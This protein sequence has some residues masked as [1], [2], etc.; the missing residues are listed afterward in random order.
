MMSN[1]WLQRLSTFTSNKNV[2]LVYNP[3]SLSGREQSNNG[4]L[5][6]LFL[7]RLGK[8]KGVYDLLE[9]VNQN[10]EYFQSK[11]ARFILAGDGEVE[12][13]RQFVA[14]HELTDLVEVPGWIL[15]EQKEKYLKTS[16]ILILPSYNEQ[17]P[18]SILEGMGYGYPI[19]ATN[20]ASIPEMVKHGENGYLFEPGDI[21]AMTLFIQ[22][23][24]EDVSLR[25][26]M[27]R[28]SQELVK[29]KFESTKIV[30]Q[31]VSIYENL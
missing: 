1:L 27:G 22:N 5:N 9:C 17:M 31:L 29:E 7:G 23:L 20:I 18:M 15:S 11:K 25:E 16:D 12:K 3:I 19:L 10:K 24:C 8:R 4:K 26:K 13:T 2:L 14:D 30:D 6:I 21:R 28:R